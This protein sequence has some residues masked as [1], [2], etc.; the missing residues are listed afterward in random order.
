M[1]HKVSAAG[2]NNIAW[3]AKGCIFVGDVKMFSKMDTLVIPISRIDRMG[4]NR[5]TLGKDV[6]AVYVG[7][8]RVDFK[9]PTAEVLMNEIIA[10]MTGEPS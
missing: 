3:V 10:V 7:G 9:T 6:L 2:I 1:Q 5:R 4:I 8:E